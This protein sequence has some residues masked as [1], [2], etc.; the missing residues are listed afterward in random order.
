MVNVIVCC[1]FIGFLPTK[2]FEQDGK[3]T[4]ETVHDA[5]TIDGG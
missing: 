3:K 2:P 5:A 1:H 4:G